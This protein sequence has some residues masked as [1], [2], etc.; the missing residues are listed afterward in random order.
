MDTKVLIEKL[1]KALSFKYP[2]DRM[3]PGVTISYLRSGEFYVSLLRYTPEKSVIYKNQ[4][5]DLSTALMNAAKFLTREKAERNALDELNDAL[6]PLPAWPC[7][8]PMAYVDPS[9]K[10]DVSKNPWALCPDPKGYDPF[11]DEDE[12]FPE[13]TGED[14]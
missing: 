10:F 13:F 4:S 12:P 9:V 7:P 14:R 5:V 1:T 2:N 3:M 6:N 11:E 8:D